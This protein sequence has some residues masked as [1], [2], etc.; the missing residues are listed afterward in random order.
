MPRWPGG[1]IRKTPVTPAGPYQDGTA[2]GVWSMSDAAYWIKQGLWPTAGKQ[3]V[4][5]GL[6]GSS[7]N[8]DGVG[9]KVAPSG[10]IYALV[11][12][13]RSGNIETYLIKYTAAGS[14]TWQV[15]IGGTNAEAP[16][17]LALDSSENVY[18]SMSA[19]NGSDVDTLLV[20]YNSSGAV[21]WQRNLSGLSS[22][23]AGSVAL[24]SAG[25]PVV[26]S[27]GAF[28][29]NYYKEAMTVKYNSSGTIQWQRALSSLDAG[30]FAVALDS[31]DN[32]YVCGQDYRVSSA[33]G[34]VAKLNSSGVLQWSVAIS[35]SSAY[36]G[37]A[38][39]GAGNVYVVGNYLSG[40]YY[41]LELQKLDASGAL[42][43]SRNVN[44]G[45]GSYSISGYGVTLDSS[46]N[47]YVVG[48][49]NNDM[50]ILQYNSSGTLQWQR[51]I[52]GF[53]GV[54]GAGITVDS[55]FMY[56]TGTAYSAGA[57]GRE[58]VVGKLPK[59]G[60]L[61]GTYGSWTYTTPTYS[62][63]T[64]LSPGSAFMTSTGNTLTGGTPSYS[65]GTGTLTST[66]T[67]L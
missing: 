34:F 40:S 43:W 50:L 22:E 15:Y 19:N 49:G 24:D 39:T 11:S 23:Q 27:D 30:V 57:G 36:Y 5:L 51:S 41:R 65:T 33:R 48:S 16:K 4:W 31:S 67:Q 29:P 21:Q 12:G 20:K 59:D 8:D 38:V 54:T 56:I 58:A 13:S 66:V 3:A 61:T 18:V 47:V 52:T 10:A 42:V 53:G 1:L 32:V 46:E 26:G 45:S 7:G 37:V 44:R 35:G 6:L 28:A 64:G 62:T 60:S 14:I 55:T 25:N 2:P 63:G 9:V 17:G